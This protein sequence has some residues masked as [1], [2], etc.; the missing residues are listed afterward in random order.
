MEKI[1]SKA[2]DDLN[3]ETSSS[4]FQRGATVKLNE[5]LLGVQV[6]EQNAEADGAG[7]E[8]GASEEMKNEVTD[9]AEK[10]STLAEEAAEELEEEEESG[11]RSVKLPTHIKVDFK[12]RTWGNKILYL[13]YKLFRILLV[14]FWFYFVPFVAMFASYVIP[15]YMS[16]L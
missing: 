11:E 9:E 8:D 13:I 12:E 10:F 7:I 3:K 2:R 14:S 1:N 16:K 4:F 5:P 6:D 15:A